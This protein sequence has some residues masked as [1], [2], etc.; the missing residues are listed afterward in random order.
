[1]I[2]FQEFEK[3]ARLNREVIVT[4]KIDGTNGQV[5]IRPALANEMETGFEMGYD[6]QIEVNG[7]PHYIRAG[8]RNRWV[9]HLGSDDNNGFG[10][11]VYQH[12]HELA[13]LGAGAHFGEWWG[14]GIQR[15]Y[16][17]TEKRWSLFNVGRWV[18][19]RNAAM[20]PTLTEKEAYAPECCHVVPI[21]ASGIG[22]DEPVR[23]ALEC[24]RSNGSIAA[25]G[26]FNPEGIVAFHT[27]ART[28]FKVTLERDQEPKSMRAA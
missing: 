28:L 12:A 5:H 20:R 10:R 22:T 1:M 7:T 11:W 3:I 8:S 15:K 9:L 27:H 4:E 21:L 13:G 17:L 26:F 24:L 18:D 19:S 6:T 16:G 14:Q 25:P 23:R 2:E